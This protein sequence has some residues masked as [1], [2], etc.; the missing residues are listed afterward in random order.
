MP[1]D[2]IHTVW[3]V[4]EKRLSASRPGMGIVTLD[5]EVRN[6]DDVVVQDGFDVVMINARAT[7]GPS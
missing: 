6:Q 3:T 2:T 4:R 7:D 1:G 5:L